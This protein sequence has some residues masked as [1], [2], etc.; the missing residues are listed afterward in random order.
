MLP[1]RSHIQAPVNDFHRSSFE[2]VRRTVTDFRQAPRT[3]PTQR[4]SAADDFLLFQCPC[5]AVLM[6]FEVTRLACGVIRLAP[7]SDWVQFVVFPVLGIRHTSVLF[8]GSVIFN[9]VVT[10][11]RFAGAFPIC[12][13]LL[14]RIFDVTRVRAATEVVPVVSLLAVFI[15]L[16]RPTT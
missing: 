9:F 1:V 6:W 13:F 15:S 16:F 14:H 7:A 4:Q 3:R 12:W 2:L 10:S 11:A 5:H 8:T